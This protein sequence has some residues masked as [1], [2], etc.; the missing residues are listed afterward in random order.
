MTSPLERTLEILASSQNEAATETLM[1][2]MEQGDRAI[3]DG[4]IVALMR[5][6]GKQGHL[7]ILGK[8]HEF[9][10]DQHRLLQSGR[11][12]INGALRDAIV[13]GDDQL[14]VNACGLIEAFS[15]FDL[16]PTLIA[17][18]ENPKSPHSIQ[19]SHRVL[20]LVQRLS[21]MLH[22]PLDEPSRRNPTLMRRH[23]L[24]NL[25]RCIDRFR[26]HKRLELIESFVILSGPSSK[27]LRSIL[28]APHHA[29]FTPVLQILNENQSLGV[30]KLLIEFMQSPQAPHVVT[31][32]VSRRTDT[33]FVT[34]LLAQVDIGFSP[35]MRKNLKKIEKFSWL[36]SIL[37]SAS[38]DL[39]FMAREHGRQLVKL[40]IAASLPRETRLGFLENILHKGT[41][42]GRLAACEALA[43]IEGDWPN[44]LLSETLDDTDPA[45][46]AAAALQIRNRHI[47]GS[48]P[49]LLILLDSPHEV[50]REAAREALQDLSFT[51][52]LSRFESLSDEVRRSTGP[53]VSK[54]DLEAVPLL[55]VELSADF[56]GRRLRAIEMAEVMD[57][58][59]R[60]SEALI[61]RLRDEDHLVRASAANVLRECNRNDVR[62][63]LRDATQDRSLA[64]Q[65]AARASL[66]SMPPFPPMPQPNGNQPLGVM[67]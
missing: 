12:H 23:V 7:A 60:I 47:P 48:L 4:A 52:Y 26:Q 16:V 1:A 44:R 39:S 41:D 58:V 63:A 17:V 66:E 21:D 28:Q 3:H 25:E 32:V 64:V 19:A 62:T 51:N 56:R 20:R 24:E 38:D 35:E 42:S 65:N 11:G 8:L 43:S 10:A 40:V 31:Q 5:R 50:V 34:E 27:L 29:C 15:E 61:E 18:A 59:P 14:F 36:D 13:S 22:A 33:L 53:L 67:P 2:A 37:K 54:V 55:L 45:V 30:V 6:H 46:Q 57:L 49:R 9:T